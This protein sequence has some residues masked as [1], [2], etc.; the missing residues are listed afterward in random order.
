MSGRVMKLSDFRTYVRKLRGKLVGADGAIVR[1]I[2]SGLARSISVVH[3]SVENAVPAS[4]NGAVGAFNTG[5]YRQAWQYEVTPTG[6]RLFNSRPYAGVIER[7]RRAG[8]RPPPRREIVLWAMRR[9]GLSR[10]EAERAS[11]P[12]SKAITRRGLGGRRVLTN[13]GTADKITRV[14]MEEVMREVQGALD[15]GSK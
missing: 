5:A 2:H 9:L 13:P 8:S 1:G 10:E 14:V 12:I 4:P 7:G 15:R 11:Y 3:A 6:G